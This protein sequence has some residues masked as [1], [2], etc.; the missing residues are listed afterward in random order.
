MKFPSYD[1]I[2]KALADEQTFHYYME[3]SKKEQFLKIAK[4]FADKTMTKE[5]VNN[6]LQLQMMLNPVLSNQPN[7]TRIMM[8]LESVL[9]EIAT[10]E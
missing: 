1:V 9:V 2:A 4:I 7:P 5:S 3:G 10:E 8:L 6:T